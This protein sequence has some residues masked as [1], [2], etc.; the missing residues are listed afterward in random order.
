[1]VVLY[2]AR[3]VKVKVTPGTLLREVKVRACD[4]LSLDAERYS[5]KSGKSILSD[6]LPF[7]LSNLVQN[8]K[9][10]LV[11]A[12][13]KPAAGSMVQ[14]K[15]ALPETSG[16]GSFS[17]DTTIWSILKHFEDKLD[18]KITSNSVSGRYTQP[19]VQ[20]F[21]TVINTLEGL[22]KSLADYGLT[23]GNTALRVRFVQT[24]MPVEKAQSIISGFKSQQ[25]PQDSTGNTG[26]STPGSSTATP[27][28]PSTAN[29]TSSDEPA[30][31]ASD[32]SA[33]DSSAATS[34]IK[35]GGRSVRA[36][37][38]SSR[39]REIPDDANDL[40]MNS[41]QFRVYR[42]QLAQMS[43]SNRRD[44]PLMTASMREAAS[45]QQKHS[46][47]QCTVRVRMPDQT[48]VEAVFGSN[49]HVGD[50]Y[51]F[52]R[53]VLQHD[54]PFLLFQ[55]PPRRVLGDPEQELVADCDFG[56]RELL[57]F[58]WDGDDSSRPKTGL[59][60]ANVLQSAKEITETESVKIDQ[61]MLAQPETA[62]Q[63][64]QPEQPQHQPQQ[65]NNS[66]T[67]SARNGSGKSSG[68]PKWLKL[69]KK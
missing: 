18:T 50:V 29:S 58:E 3:Q 55:F 32:K 25:P 37:V 49:E 65:S 43:G 46:V 28:T 66:S 4:T 42:S 63:S 67:S 21:S 62:S 56:A 51:T 68:I 36:Y 10:E 27:A 20:L 24:S 31:S 33:S 7:R 17:S 48:H 16:V 34:E 35:Y 61:A 13:G 57:Y 38:P 45:K 5:L 54:Y 39:P 30:K 11:A 41:G 12:K 9:I 69:S 6:S 15:L 52:V 2:G 23:S 47:E 22:D 19:Q 44:G 59:L 26:A 8:A 60:K 1:M 40:E 64:S 53:S 14:I